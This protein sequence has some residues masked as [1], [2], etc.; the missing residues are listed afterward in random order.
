VMRRGS[1]LSRHSA[2]QT[3][4]NALLALGRDDSGYSAA[5]R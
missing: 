4:V 3:R 1:R 5:V 2:S